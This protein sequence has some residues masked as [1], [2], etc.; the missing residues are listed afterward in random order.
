MHW[1]GVELRSGA[2]GG[3]ASRLPDVLAACPQARST[4]SVSGAMRFARG[5]C[6]QAAAAAIFLPAFGVFFLGVVE[7][8]MGSR[9]GLS[10]L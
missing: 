9:W 5:G 1:P 2:K 7:L 4:G 6:Q 3:Q 10:N 8:N